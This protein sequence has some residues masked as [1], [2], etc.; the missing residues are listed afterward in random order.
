VEQVKYRQNKTTVGV[1]SIPAYMTPSPAIWSR[2]PIATI[3]KR[4]ELGT[5]RYEDWRNLPLAPTLTTQIAFGN[6]KAFANTGCTINRVSAINSVEKLG[7]AL[8]LATDTDND[9]A[10]IAD[11]YPSFRMSGDKAVDGKLCFEVCIAQKSVVTNM[12]STFVG[13]AETELQTLA[14][15]LPLNAGDS[16]TADG[17]MIGFRIEEDG[18]GVVDTVYADRATSFTNIGDTEGGTLVAYTFRKLGWVYDPAAPDADCVTFYA[19][20]VALATKLSRTSLQALTNLDANALGFLLVTCADSA[21]TAHELYC[22]W[23]AIGQLNP[24]VQL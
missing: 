22:P 11:A 18:L 23:Y 3:R 17:A 24:G 20:N 15:A 5:Y 12:A 19:N 1:G 21:G 13:L 2:F 10:S 8:K 4:P 9:S 16:P 14:N 7:G 6:Y